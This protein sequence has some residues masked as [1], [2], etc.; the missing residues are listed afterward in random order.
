MGITAA[1]G[2]LPQS[3]APYLEESLRKLFPIRVT[4]CN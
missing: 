1:C 3:Q 2:V 4:I